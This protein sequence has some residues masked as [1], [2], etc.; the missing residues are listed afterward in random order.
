MT[1]KTFEE[2]E[3]ELK[4]V[5]T[6]RLDSG[7]RLNI[8]QAQMG[9][10]AMHLCHDPKENPIARPYGTREGE[11]SDFGHAL[12]QLMLYGIS[13]DIN[14]E[15]A[16]N[17]AMK[18]M[19]EKDFV[20]R[21]AKDDGKIS[22]QCGMIGCIRGKAIIDPFMIRYNI[23]DNSILITSHPT[24]DA[25]LKRYAG[26]VTD[27]G[28]SACHAAIVCREFGIPCL[29]GTGNATEKIKDGEMIEIEITENGG[30]VRRINI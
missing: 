8:V 1:Q 29:V 19:Q 24:S 25:R 15:Q 13:R 21:E 20:K 22:G 12:I 9:S 4:E 14:L 28:G 6:G 23:P 16:Y 10:L 2:A 7:F 3:Q 11:V 18:S 17:I 26:V 30:I 27:H 5:Q